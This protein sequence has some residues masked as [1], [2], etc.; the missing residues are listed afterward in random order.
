MGRVW[1]VEA[2]GC[3]ERGGAKG[4]AVWDRRK[5]DVVHVLE[6]KT[7]LK[8]VWH[9]LTPSPVNPRIQPST[10]PSLAPARNQPAFPRRSMD[11][12]ANLEMGPEQHEAGA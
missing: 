3:V 12:A 7:G 8:E 4:D 1:E 2:W 9:S 6:K 10:A 5:G 11:G